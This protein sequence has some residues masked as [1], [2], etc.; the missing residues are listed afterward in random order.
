MNKTMNS[1]NKKNLFFMLLVIAIP[2]N[3]SFASG[4]YV[5][6]GISDRFEHNDKVLINVLLN[7]D[8]NLSFSRLVDI[9]EVL[10]QRKA[11]FELKQNQ[12]LASFSDAELNKTYEYGTINA[13]SGFVNRNGFEK[14]RQLPNI[15]AIEADSVVPLV[16]YDSTSTI[17]VRPKVW[18]LGYTGKYQT[19]CV[20]DG[21][22]NWQHPYLGGCSSMG[23]NCKILDGYDYCS[24]VGCT[25]EDDFPMDFFGHGTKVASVISS[26]H[27]TYRGV[28]PDSKL[29]AVKACED[30]SANCTTTAIGKA[31]NWCLTNS[32]KYNISI[33]TIS[34][35]STPVYSNDSC[36]PAGSQTVNELLAQ[37]YQAGLFIDAASG[38][39]GSDSGI[40][41]PAC[42]QNVTSVGA[43]T[44]SDG[45]WSDTNAY[46]SLDL[47]A[48]GTGI[49]VANT[50][51]SP[52]N[53]FSPDSGTSL[54]APHIAGAAALLQEVYGGNLSPIEIRDVL[55]STGKLVEDCNP[56]CTGLYTSRIDV[57]AAL[58]TDWPTNRHDN[59]RTGTTILQG[60]MQKA[61]DVDNLNLYLTNA[62]NN[63][64]VIRSSIS[65]LDNNNYTEAVSVAHEKYDAMI[66]TL[67]SFE[68]NKW[69]DS[70]PSFLGG[71][72][73]RNELK[74]SVSL[75]RS[76]LSPPSVGSIDSTLR[77]EVLAP[78]RNGSLL[79][80]DVGSNG[81]TPSQLCEFTT[82]IKHSNAIAEDY[83]G[84]LSSAAIG[85]IDL[86]GTNDIVVAD[87]GTR[88]LYDWPGEIFVL[89]SGCHK[90]FSAVFGNGGGFG[91]PSIANIDDNRYPEIIVPSFY[92][93]FVYRYNST[94]NNLTLMW[95]NSDGLIDGEVI[96]DD[97]DRDNNYELIYST[98]N[99]GCSA[100]KMCFN[101]TYIRD[102]KTGANRG[103]SPIPYNLVTRVA[104]TVANLD[105]D[106]NKEIVTIGTNQR[107]S[108]TN[109]GKLVAYDAGNGS[110]EWEYDDGGNLKVAFASPTIADITGDGQPDVIFAENNGSQVYILNKDG[111]LNFKYH[112]SAFIDNALAIGDLDNDGKAEI[113]IKRAGSP[114][115]FASLSG[116]NNPP[117]LSE[118]DGMVA[119]AG[120][121]VDINQSG[122]VLARDP[123]DNSVVYIYPTPFDSAGLW[124]TNV[125]DT[126][127]YSIT[128]EATD[129]NLSDFKSVDVIVFNEDTTLTNS[130]VDGSNK[131]LLNFTQSG[132]QTLKVRLNKDALVKY[133][134]IK[135]GG[136][137]NG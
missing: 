78:R 81:K 21:G 69:W 27:P 91:T 42:R 84:E 28:A 123:D 18:N 110:K 14:L 51:W 3:A 76:V 101:R 2:I 66:G 119:I 96:V 60:D 32:S 47:L 48:P 41:W 135:I 108:T 12:L 92:G 130:F 43:T 55:M 121:I 99:Q 45:F 8:S 90:K 134:K 85:D 4:Q 26:T 65:D 83:M 67:F 25:Q 122:Q 116:S 88:G 131:T 71:F 93:V 137:S 94:I 64:Y 34:I 11:Y 49:Y 115:A 112:F 61:S 62:N 30:S 73:Y 17:N 50:D 75:N 133:S 20:V 70:C 102:A 31:I 38:N 132:N 39:S 136:Y 129:G 56:S 36:S 89:D 113:A 13:F 86:D 77:K 97:I 126:G 29:I 117:E 114:V 124:Q 44:K 54:A 120:T 52:G 58:Q 53:Y 1:N 7:D 80:Y 23:Q 105:T 19:V 104:P 128:V 46:S 63:E 82:T 103:P 15:I 9:S 5:D 33:I 6:P 24:N 72:C 59:S 125:N 10:K 68:R 95:N 74:W 79:V 107:F 22:I 100:A 127:N 109:V 37:A 87:M 111:T 40:S 16:L 57:F 106:A 98:S 118:I 35:G